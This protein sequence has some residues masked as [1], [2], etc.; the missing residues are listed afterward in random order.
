MALKLVTAP[1]GTGKTLLLIKMI[2]EYLREGRRV[3]SN[4]DQLKIEEV[5]PIPPNADWRDY[6][7]GSVIIYDEAQEHVAFSKDDLT[8][9]EEFIEP[10]QLDDEN[11]TAYRQRIVLLKKDYD[12]RKKRY[13]ESIK[14]I[15]RGFQIHRHFGY[16]IILATQDSGLLNSLTLGIVGEHYHL[17][18]PFGMK[19]NVLLFWRRHVSN[20]DSSESIA[21][22][23]WKKRINFNKNYFHLYRSA[24][25]HT[26][27]SNFPFKYV[28]VLLIVLSLLGAPYFLF[29]NNAAVDF[30]N[31]DKKATDFGQ[32]STDQVINKPIPTSP[33]ALAN[34]NL[35]EQKKQQEE[36]EK[37]MAEQ[38]KIYAET[39]KK[40]EESQISGCVYFNGK[41]TAID[42][43][44][45]PLHNKSHLCK[46][47]IKYAD[48]TNFKKPRPV[49][50]YNNY[51]LAT[52]SQN[53]LQ[54][55]SVE[56]QRVLANDVP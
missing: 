23:E 56:E 38:R 3:Y 45:R 21:R 41:Y 50:S 51:D 39:I 25:V 28:L 47:V 33:E 9:F 11:V 19:A 48:R 36:R 32:S 7:D 12:R 13:L 22:V 4:I 16:D 37:N 34:F 46:D 15:A 1:P 30:Y 8:N 49:T 2:F 29:K 18:R 42:E 43:Y 55:L 6:P 17:K 52:D 53:E 31:G 24:N 44:T 35:E 5:L 10:E 27:K 54:Q 20:P 26:H 14:D 40:D